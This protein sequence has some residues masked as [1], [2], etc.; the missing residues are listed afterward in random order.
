MKAENTKNSILIIDDDST[1][2]AVLEH[3]LS[4]EYT[5]YAVKDGRFAVDIARKHQP[6]IV[7]LDIVMPDMDGFDVLSVLKKTKE[8][9]EIPVI[10]ITGVDGSKHEEKGLGMGAEDY[11]NKPFVGAIV[12][13][14]V[15]NQIKLLRAKRAVEKAQQANL[16][17]SRFLSYLSHE[18]RTP[19]NA[20]MGIANVS[21][22]FDSTVKKSEDIRK[23]AQLSYHM[24]G[25][26]N[27]ILDISK[28]EAGK[29][30][31]HISS[32]SFK[33]MIDTVAN[34]VSVMVE[35]KKIDFII[36]LNESVP[37]FITSD[38]L[39][40]AQ[41]IINLLTNAIK[42]TPVGGTVTLSADCPKQTDKKTPDACVLRVEVADNGIGIPAEQ[43]TRLFDAFEQ[44][45]MNRTN[46]EFGGT[47]LGLAISKRIVGMMGGD[48]WLESESGKGSRFI[49]TIKIEQQETA[50]REDD[51]LSV[52]TGDNRFVGKRVLIA[53]DIDINRE[54]LIAQLEGSGLSIDTATN[55]RE[56]VEML[57]KNLDAYDL[58][59][60]DIE[61]PEMDGLEAA[62]R[63]RSISKSLPVIAMTAR[64]FTD[65]VEFCLAAGMDDH[66]GKPFDMRVVYEKLKKYLS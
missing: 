56:A 30:E 45:E 21:K 5:I 47:G 10:F 50:E 57:T 29:F 18:L 16:A 26:L 52:H 20:I 4:E 34:F 33:K 32:F 13:L 65:D 19:M 43:Q 40:L 3:L 66:I 9:K 8:T 36:N 17:K 11:I 24:Q 15:R 64:V 55:G 35:E 48:V 54:V 58:V 51:F 61:M 41:V 31:L 46:G 1:D 2:I 22:T 63:I 12:Q 59:F 6:D 27:Q 44:A 23:I 53:E 60:M 37:R 7:L 38:E 42:F 49:F 28:I 62:R 25:I 39:R 14:R